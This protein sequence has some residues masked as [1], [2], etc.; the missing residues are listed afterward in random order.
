MKNKI[1]LNLVSSIIFFSI[2]NNTFNLGVLATQ[3]ISSPY[4]ICESIKQLKKDNSSG[5]L[6]IYA[7][8]EYYTNKL[9]IYFYTNA[10]PDLVV[11]EDEN[12]FVVMKDKFN[13]KTITRAFLE[14]TDSGQG[15]KFEVEID[16]LYYCDAVNLYFYKQKGDKTDFTIKEENYI[17]KVKECMP[18]VLLYKRGDGESIKTYDKNW[19]EISASGKLF[20]SRLTS[21]YYCLF[22]AINGRKADYVGK[23]V[24][25][26]GQENLL[27]EEEKIV[28]C[29]VFMPIIKPSSGI[30]WE[31]AIY[32]RSNT[33]NLFIPEGVKEFKFI[34]YQGA[35]SND[36]NDIIN[37]YHIKL[38]R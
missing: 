21:N 37:Q 2:F 4:L 29:E 26:Q 6:E 27:T 14:K 9:K 13:K 11:G 10:S 19:N 35:V 36:P 20:L 5:F 22:N 1:F 18:N 3:E 31:N 33:F 38:A 32:T 24:L 8:V 25:N 34:V 7:N 23:I 16:A 28:D 17:G 12:V 15:K 30:T